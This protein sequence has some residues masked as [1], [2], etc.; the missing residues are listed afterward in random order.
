[1]QARHIAREL[2]LLSISQLPVKPE[3]LI[4]KTIDDMVIAAV[5]S[6][7]EEVKEL[8]MT[9]SDELQRGQ[10]MLFSSETRAADLAT[11]QVM[12]KDA[13][14]LTQTA[15]NRAGLALEFPE[16]IQTARQ[17]EVRAYVIQILQTIYEQRS[18]IDKLITGALVDWQLNRLSQVD[19]HILRI[20]TA[21]I[22]YLQVPKAIA[23]NEAVE[24]AKRYSSQDGYR[25]INGVL[26]NI[27]PIPNN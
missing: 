1:M 24:L 20:A 26:R 19:Q 8:I 7:T 21:E 10:D 16:L 25:F 14:A 9:A 27:N 2:V 18:H 5:R 13:I 6:L 11:A 12:V 15:I 23:V 17:Q 22:A 4:T 3:N